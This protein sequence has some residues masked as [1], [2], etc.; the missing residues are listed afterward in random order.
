MNY[1]NVYC[2]ES[3]QLERDGINA[4]VLGAVWCPK[5]SVKKISDQIRLIKA[6]NS[7]AETAEMK[8]GKASPSKN[9]LFQ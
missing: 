4:M 7:V 5:D 8:W 3:C 9:Q 6:R 1:Y 2:D